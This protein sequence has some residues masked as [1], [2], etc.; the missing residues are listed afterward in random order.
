[1][2]AAKDLAAAIR[3]IAGASDALIVTVVSVDKVKNTCE[4]D[5]DGSELGNVQLQAVIKADVKGCRIYPAVG[6]KV[7]IETLNDKGGYMVSLY[8]EVEEMVNEIGTT[9]YKMNAGGHTIKKDEDNIKQALKMIV[10]SQMQML[11]LYG[12]NADFVKLQQALVIIENVLD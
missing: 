7:V 12:N 3:M 2:K 1:M 4:V 11:I 5:I 8:S 6:S 9:I 10:E